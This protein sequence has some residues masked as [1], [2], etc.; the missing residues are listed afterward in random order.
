MI[1]KLKYIIVDDDLFCN[2]LGAM[3]IKKTLGETDVT[4]F[5][6][7]ERGLAYIRNK[8]RNS[9]GSTILLLDINMPTITGWEFLQVLG[10]FGDEIKPPLSIYML[11]SSINQQDRDK[12]DANKFVKGFISKPLS[13]EIVIAITA[14]SVE[15]VS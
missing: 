3:I 6:M 11:S 15:S 2:T 9:F 7:P 1:N 13:S 8:P 4:V 14:Q 10:S 12:A 5:D